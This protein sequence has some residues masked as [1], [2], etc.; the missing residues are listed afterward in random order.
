MMEILP[1]IYGIGFVVSVLVFYQGGVRGKARNS[2]LWA[3]LFGAVWFITMPLVIVAA[4]RAYREE[5][6]E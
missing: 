6:G 5:K 1:A 2:E 4:V 3:L